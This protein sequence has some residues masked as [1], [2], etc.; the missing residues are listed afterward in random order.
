MPSSTEYRFVP[1]NEDN[2][3]MLSELNLPSTSNKLPAMKTVLKRDDD[4]LPAILLTW[5]VQVMGLTA[6]LI[7]GTFSILSWIDSQHA[8]AQANAANIIALAAMCV[9]LSST[10]CC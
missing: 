2:S 7:F 5:F 8:K 9:Q 10:V 6:A 1:Q 3:I 4:S